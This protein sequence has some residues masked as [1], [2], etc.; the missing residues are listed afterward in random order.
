MTDFKP[1]A[2]DTASLSLGGLTVENGTDRIALYGNI[3]IGRTPADLERVR[4]LSSLLAE[5]ERSI[6]ADPGA[7]VAEA[8]AAPVEVRNPFA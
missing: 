6:A 5:I 2:D 8:D 7:E 4:R 1:F 3:D